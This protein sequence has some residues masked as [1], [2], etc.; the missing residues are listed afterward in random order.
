IVDIDVVLHTEKPTKLIDESIVAQKDFD[1]KCERSN[2][3]CLMAMKRTIFKNILGGLP[4]TNNAKEFFTIVGQ[5][6]LVS[7]TARS[8]MSE[9]MSMRYDGMGCVK[10]YILKLV[11]LQSN[12]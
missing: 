7:N 1:A 10:E 8:L 6:Y 4:D 11:S 3:L 9:L 2:H 12:I 5:R